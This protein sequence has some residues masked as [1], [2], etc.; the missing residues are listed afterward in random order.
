[1]YLFLMSLRFVGDIQMS[2]FVFLISLQSF[3]HSQNLNDRVNVIDANETKDFFEFEEILHPPSQ[4]NEFYSKPK[5]WINGIIPYKFE[6][7]FPE[8][9][10]E[11]FENAIY[12]YKGLTHGCVR[13]KKRTNE[14]DYLY[15]THTKE[16]CSSYIGR[17]GGPQEM[18]LP[19]HCNT[20]HT[21]LHELLHSLGFDHEH[22]RPDRDDYVTIL[23]D[24]VK[25]GKERLFEK[26]KNM[27][28]FGISYD[29]ESVMHYHR[30]T[31]SKNDKPTIITK[32]PKY[33]DKIG[34]A[35][36]LSEKDIMK[37][38]KMYNC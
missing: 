13:F 3:I 6:H 22:Q 27:E 23:H 4:R 5:K 20:P 17:I 34:N 31:F 16:R 33:Q 15:I 26:R 18:S 37:V 25:K 2:S 12:I 32:N 28:T 36:V 7:N 11:T 24:N 35:L 29:Y 8:N 1:M 19:T 9:G 38:K 10:I 14:Q 30:M 21:V